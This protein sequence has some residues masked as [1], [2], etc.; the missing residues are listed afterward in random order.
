MHLRVIGA[1]LPRLDQAGIALF[2]ASDVASFK[3]TMRDLV[4]RGISKVTPE[5]IEDR[6]LEH[7]EELDADLQRCALF[8]IEVTGN[9]REF[10]PTEFTNPESGYVGWE[11]VFLSMEGE[12]KVTESYRAPA[13][14]T[15]FRVAF[16][17]HEW[18]EP[19]TLVGPT[20][21]LALPA[22]TPVPARLWKLAPYS[23]VD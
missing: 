11:P 18:D 7:P 3:E 23:C 16:Y 15:D 22:F 9:D 12:S 14:M 5:E 21:S 2:I 6:A 1:H 4:A 19:G 8:E 20:G 10:D 17:I 13:S